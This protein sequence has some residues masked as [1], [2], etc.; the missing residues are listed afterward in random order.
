MF[1]QAIS[2]SEMEGHLCTVS[3]GSSRSCELAVLDW[4]NC[5]AC[6]SEGVEVFHRKSRGSA[7]CMVVVGGD[8]LPGKNQTRQKNLSN[9]A[10]VSISPTKTWTLTVTGRFIRQVIAV[11]RY[12]SWRHRDKETL[13]NISRYTPQSF[14]SLFEKPILHKD[15]V[16]YHSPLNSKIK[17]LRIINNNDDASTTGIIC[18][19]VFSVILHL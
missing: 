13:H 15:L 6:F 3:S 19:V 14:Y 12:K 18:A 16:R 7:W 10:M 2:H 11:H 8:V 9:N 17:K 1:S 5:N 4:T